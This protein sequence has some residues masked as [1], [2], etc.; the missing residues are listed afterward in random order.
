VL[1]IEVET[2]VSGRRAPRSDL[3]LV[4]IKA[5]EEESAAHEALLDKMTASGECV[6]RESND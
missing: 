3:N 5:N 6:W 4:V 2:N 1:E